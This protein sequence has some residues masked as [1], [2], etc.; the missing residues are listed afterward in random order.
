M[1]N[2]SDQA[3]EDAAAGECVELADT[4]RALLQTGLKFETD[5][6]FTLAAENY[7]EALKLLQPEDIGTFKALHWRLGRVAEELGDNDAAEEHYN[8]VAATDYR[9][10]EEFDR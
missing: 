4:I 1:S 9:C 5:G 2:P 8:K 3:S 7:R 6:D 10:L